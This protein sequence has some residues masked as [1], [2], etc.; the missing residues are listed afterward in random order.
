MWFTLIG[1]QDSLISI[2]S[3]FFET[4]DAVFLSYE[5]ARKFYKWELLELPFMYEYWE[6]AEPIPG[7]DDDRLIPPPPEGKCAWIR[8]LCKKNKAVEKTT[9]EQEEY[10]F[11]R[12]IANYATSMYQKLCL[13]HI[14]TSQGMR[15]QVE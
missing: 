4:W 14:F 15:L 13:D 12:A 2:H 7:F 8:K 1:L 9:A 5:Y 11:L 10:D 6:E 3:I